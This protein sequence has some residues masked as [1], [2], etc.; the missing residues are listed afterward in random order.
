MTTWQAHWHSLLRARAI[1]AQA[2]VVA[3]AQGGEHLS[4]AGEKRYTYGH[5]LIV[6]PWG[7]IM[8][9]VNEVGPD[10]IVQSLKRTTIDKVRKQIPMQNHRKLP[11]EK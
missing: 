1:E 8:N 3:A 10:F 11:N 5:S 7:E 6:G 4:M 9:E 2:Y